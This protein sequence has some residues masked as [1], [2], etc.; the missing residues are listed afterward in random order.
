MVS[1][2]FHI[3]IWIIWRQLHFTVKQPRPPCDGYDTRHVAKR[4]HSHPE[5]L[6]PLGSFAPTGFQNLTFGQHSNSNQENNSTPA[7]GNRQIFKQYYGIAM[8]LPA[9]C[10]FTR[11][12]QAV[13]SGFPRWKAHLQ[14]S[15]CPSNFQDVDL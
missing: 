12:Q 2:Q 15:G 3:A 10:P 6:S 4:L 9:I 8:F 14:A 1:M 11:L 13:H 7:T 5:R